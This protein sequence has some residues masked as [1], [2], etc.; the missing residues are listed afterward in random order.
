MSPCKLSDANQFSFR[1]V[2]KATYSHKIQNLLPQPN[3]CDGYQINWLARQLN[4][5]T[6]LPTMARLG[7]VGLALA[8]LA[9]SSEVQAGRAVNVGVEAAFPAG[10][11]LLELLYVMFR[12]CTWSTGQ[13]YTYK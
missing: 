13:E 1:S 6:L 2:R 9:L 10:P 12:Y 8:L 3:F 7:R 11:Y 4:N 5:G